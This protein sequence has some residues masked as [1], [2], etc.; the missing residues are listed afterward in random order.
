MTTSIIIATQNRAEALREC[1]QSIASQSSLPNSV[2]VVDASDDEMTHSMIRKYVP[3]MP[4]Q[5][6]YMRAETRSAARQRN[7]GARVATTDFLFFLDD[8]VVLEPDFVAEIVKVF[9]ADKEGVIAGIGGTIVNEVYF[10]PSAVNRLLLRA[11]TGSISGSYA[12]RLLGPGVN[13]LPRDSRSDPERVDW[14]R[15]GCTAYRRVVFEEFRFSESFYGYSFAEDVHLSARIGKRY[16]LFS[17]GRARLYHKGLGGR[18]HPDW[19]ARG[20][21]MII[22]RHEIM[23]G[24]LGK[25]STMDYVRLTLFE[26]VYG[27]VAGMWNGGRVGKVRQTVFITWGRLR[28]LMKILMGTTPHRDFER[29]VSDLRHSD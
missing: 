8:D 6:T 29:S 25:K 26:I 7:Q 23:A 14:L 27:F 11:C 19:V 3:S 16:K 15:S 12:G 2:I 10:P 5:T 20:E 17:T 21:M 18:D 13:F 28:G 22:N 4:F 1:L 24:I 9:E